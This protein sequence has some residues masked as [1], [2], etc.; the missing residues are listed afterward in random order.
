MKFISK[1]CAYAMINNVHNMLYRHSNFNFSG[2]EIFG[3]LFLT[4]KIAM[5]SHFF[6]FIDQRN[7]PLGE[8]VINVFIDLS[9]AFCCLGNNE[10]EE[11]NACKESNKEPKHPKKH[12]SCLVHRP[13]VSLEPTEVIVTH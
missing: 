10:I 2:N 1:V 6:S 7:F 4:I 5:W 8:N 13:F 11:N 9:I 12:S 3:E